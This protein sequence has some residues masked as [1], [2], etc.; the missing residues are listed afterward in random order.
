MGAASVR[1]AG[2]D[3]LRGAAAL[4]V[5][6]YHAP[7]LFGLAWPPSAYLAVDLF[8]CLSGFVIAHAYTGRLASGMTLG[9]FVR[10]RLVRLYP[11]YLLGLLIAAPLLLVKL[12][13]G[14]PVAQGE[15]LALIP[16]VLALPSM[17][18]LALYPLNLASWSLAYEVGANA[19]MAAAWRWLT[20]AR[21]AI[22]TGVA[23]AGVVAGAI[24]YGSLETGAG[25]NTVPVTL[26]RVAFSF[27]AGVLI[28]RVAPRLP[29][30]S[31]WL[32][33]AAVGA[34]FWTRGGALFD[35]VAVGLI[36]PVVVAF[37]A[38]AGRNAVLCWAGDRSYA[39]YILHIPLLRW[40]T[41]G[42]ELSG[43][44]IAP[45]PIAALFLLALLT[46]SAIAD[47]LWDAPFRHLLSAKIVVQGHTRETLIGV[48]AI[49]GPEVVDRKP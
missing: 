25:W 7:H 14:L 22:I 18:T 15:V 45:G 29:R 28:Y 19:V 43:W 6:A 40:F 49:A 36:F 3:A 10:R 9:D 23:G 16:N 41:G 24:L 30:V 39:I 42:L 2:L 46:A 4:A 21:L 47:R 35:V 38:N 44:V 8:F 12:V 33:I 20:I 32:L 34:V 26:A 17:T 13:F 27:T 37:G 5:V 1:F 11:L 31:P 48:H